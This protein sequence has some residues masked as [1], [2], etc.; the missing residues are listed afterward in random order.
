MLCL[1]ESPKKY[2]TYE[3]SLSMGPFFDM[4]LIHVCELNLT[5]F[6]VPSLAP[7]VLPNTSLVFC[8]AMD[9]PLLQP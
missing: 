2:Y 9:F 5:L 1:K 7:M 6:V 4:P 3:P 8:P